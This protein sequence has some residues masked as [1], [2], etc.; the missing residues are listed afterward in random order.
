M[1]Y[2]VNDESGSIIVIVAL[3]ITV[4]F[5]F[6]AL[7]VDVGYLFQER[8]RLQTAADAA[9]LAAARSMATAAASGALLGAANGVEGVAIQTGNYDFD[10]R[11]FTP[12][13][14]PLNAVR[15]VAATTRTAFFAGV[16]GIDAL[17]VAAQAVALHDFAPPNW[18]TDGEMRFNGTFNMDT[19]GTSVRFH[20][21]DNIIANGNPGITG[22]LTATAAGDRNDLGTANQPDMTIPAIDWAALQVGAEVRSPASGAETIDVAS[23]VG[24]TG[25]IYVDGDVVLTGGPVN[26]SDLTIAASGSIT[27]DGV[28]IYGEAGEVSVFLVSRDGMLMQG[29]A[30]ALESMLLRTEGDFRSNGGGNKHLTDVYVITSG[31]AVSN[32]KIPDFDFSG[33][34]SIAPSPFALPG[35]RWRLMM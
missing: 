18:L 13:A 6:S 25:T 7:V 33:G 1:P 5:G 17:G 34:V 16:L 15:A 23:L 19:G 22:E 30:S 27:I 3:F 11:I 32:G 8:Q 10:A 26:L 12:G 2:R 31:S 9:A 29:G 20:S 14:A 24:K 35:E 4:L 28:T 21:N